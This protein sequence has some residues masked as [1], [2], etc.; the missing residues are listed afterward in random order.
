MKSKEPTQKQTRIR[1]KAGQIIDSVL[2]YLEANPCSTKQQ[3]NSAVKNGSLAVASLVRQ[4]MVAEIKINDPT[5]N[6]RTAVYSIT[7]AQQEQ[8]QS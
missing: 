4:G 3:I 8:T 2:S 5:T 6:R 1:R 7:H